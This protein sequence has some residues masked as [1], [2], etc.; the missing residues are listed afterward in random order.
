[1]SNTP[2]PH[3]FIPDEN[4][5]FYESKA[6][7]IANDILECELKGKVDEKWVNSWAESGG[8][9]EVRHNNF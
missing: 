7:L 8:K 4:H 2:P 5:R 1:M 6:T 9:F 3:N